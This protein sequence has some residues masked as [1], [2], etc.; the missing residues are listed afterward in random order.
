MADTDEDLIPSIAQ[1]HSLGPDVYAALDDDNASDSSADTDNAAPDY[2]F[3]TGTSSG[4]SAKDKQK[5]P[6]RGTKDFEPNPTMRQAST[7]DISRQAMADALGFVRSHS[8]KSSIVGV[9]FPHEADWDGKSWDVIE[10]EETQV[11]SASK[12]QK[13]RKSGGVRPGE[14]RC[15]VVEKFTSSHLKTIGQSDRRN[16]VWLLPEE[17][18]YLLERGSLDIRWASE[19]E[20]GEEETSNVQE[21]EQDAS[22]LAEGASEPD[23]S[24]RSVLVSSEKAAAE[25]RSAQLKI[26]TIPM[27]LQGAY[28]SLIGK[29]GLTLDR[30]TVYANMKRAGY[31]V[32]RAPTWYG[33]VEEASPSPE[34][35]LLKT[36][37]S[38]HVSPQATNTIF[39]F[40]RQ[41]FSWLFSPTL[42]SKSIST[43]CFNSAIGPLI[44]PGLF[45][46][47]GDIYRQLFLIPYY[48]HQNNTT[49]TDRPTTTTPQSSTAY[50]P[51][52]TNTYSTTTSPLLPT[53]HLYKPALLSI[54]RKTAPPPPS[55]HLVVID[56][57]S[58]GTSTIPTSQEIG[59]LLDRM[60]PNELSR[61]KRLETRIKH[62]T[63]NF[64][65][66][67]V[68][69]GLIS[70]LRISGG[71]FKDGGIW[72]ENERKKK[73]T[74]RG[75]KGGGFRG[76]GGGRGRG[77][78]RG[79]GGGG[80]RGA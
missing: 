62:G 42:S 11:A 59:V 36:S 79:G 15:V 66:A 48:K 35:Q 23:S 13:Y 10:D 19:E 56:S 69:S 27:S 25:A 43:P 41:L 52:N 21:A 33:P 14:G 53:Y 54:Y 17:A 9:Y 31:I 45:H 30:Y 40:L 70:Y 38:N 73:Q 67:V 2:R 61:D 44:S 20:D 7:L 57:R 3:L 76:R 29:S 60:P 5:L 24:A 37:T 68:D 12:E 72:E 39:S 63:R 4:S 8:A 65:L 51:T 74:A 6:A 47:Y 46:S 78:G 58:P 64:L 55:F 28:A 22:H 77:R 49:T 32:Q 1:T 75:K 26:G 16:W 71:G 34:T 80:S 18:L 50:S